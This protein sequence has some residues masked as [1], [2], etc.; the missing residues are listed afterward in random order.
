MVGS[1][2]VGNVE[3]GAALDMI[4][5]PRNPRD[6]M[7]DVPAEAW[8]PYASDV[9]VEG[10][11]QLYYGHFF[12]RSQGKTIMVDTGMGPGPHP[13]RGNRKGDLLNQLALQGVKPE[14]VDI[15]AHTH[16]HADHVGWNLDLTGAKPRPNF[17]KARYL[18]PK[19]D[20]EHF[21][22]PDNLEK[23]PWVRDSV[24]PLEEMGLMDLFESEHAITPEVTTLATPGHTPGHQVILISSRGEK[25]MIVGDVLH[26]KVQ[27]QEAGWCAGVDTNKEDSKRSREALLHRAESENYVVAAGHFHPQEHVGK[28]VRLKGRRYWQAI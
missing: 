10:Q 6:F 12:V 28:V 22:K 24:L 18:V 17:P 7:P 2:R 27:V 19:T 3:I 14:D 25:A 11:L 1:I 16:L 13:T 15:V 23:A 5:P 4:P 9:L 8:T 26:S 20:W 21:I